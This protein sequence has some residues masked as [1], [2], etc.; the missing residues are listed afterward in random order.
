MKKIVHLERE[1][2]YVSDEMSIPASKVEVSCAMSDF[3]S[4]S[5]PAGFL[6]GASSVPSPHG[7][8]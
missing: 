3:I 8:F 2:A 4:Q 6:L 5:V 1:R 7:R